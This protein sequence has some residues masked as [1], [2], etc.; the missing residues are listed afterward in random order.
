VR[1]LV[2]VLRDGRAALDWLL[3]AIDESGGPA[4]PALVLLDINLPLISGVEVLRRM[5]AHPQL[6]TL[7]VVILSTSRERRDLRDGYIAGRQ[8]SAPECR[9]R[10]RGR[11]RGPASGAA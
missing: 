1:N 2:V 10:A 8:A 7:P 5:R 4:L 6:A 11:A 9:N 3:A